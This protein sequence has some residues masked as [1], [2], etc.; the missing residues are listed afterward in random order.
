MVSTAQQLIQ[1]VPAVTD[2]LGNVVFVFPYQLASDRGW[3]G[4]VSIGSN[5]AGTFSAHDDSGNEW[6]TW[7]GSAPFGP[8]TIQ[9]NIRFTITGSGLQP[10]TQY[11]AR[12]IGVGDL[13]SN[14]TATP[15]PAPIGASSL[16]GTDSI[17]DEMVF[18]VPA[19]TSQ[20]F[21]FFPCINFSSMRLAAVLSDD[22]PAV[23]EAKWF[24]AQGTAEMGYRR[25]V[26][27][28]T[29]PRLEVCVPHLGDQLAITISSQS[30]NDS[31]FS[32]CVTHTTQILSTFGGLDNYATGAPLTVPTGPSNIIVPSFI[33][34]G[35]AIF[36]L[37]ARALAAGYI[38]AIQAQEPDGTFADLQVYDQD[39]GTRLLLPLFLPAAPL[40]FVIFNNTGAPQDI[41][42][43]L[44]LDLHTAA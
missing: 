33:Y 19:G 39:D 21:Q 13:I 34:G 28:A 20:T 27:G 31:T 22:G 1:P 14:I 12:F 23:I 4:T 24:N 35:P 29:G 9:G 43:D 30:A 18:A 25:Y 8:V 32:L 5:Q 7:S 3:Q 2:E 6:G 26:I 10:N 40:Q 42:A 16:V 15:A 11:I 44:M 17:I 41:D 36:N 38:L 37:N